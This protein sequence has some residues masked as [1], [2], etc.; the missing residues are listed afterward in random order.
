MSKDKNIFSTS[1]CLPLDTILRYVNEELSKKEMHTVEKH[2][3]DCELCQEAV[4]G[5]SLME[6]RQVVAGRISDLNQ[7]IVKEQKIFNY[8]RIAA[9]IAA[10]AILA[11]GLVYLSHQ[12][13]TKDSLIVNKN[14]KDATP[15]HAPNNQ[16]SNE[17]KSI[18]VEDNLQKKQD[19]FVNEEDIQSDALIR[20]QPETVIS[21][22]KAENSSEAENTESRIN[23][24]VIY[25]DTII[26]ESELNRNTRSVTTPENTVKDKQ[27]AIQESKNLERNQ[28]GDNNK[29]KKKSPST[30]A[31]VSN[32]EDK[33][34]ESITGP[35]LS[36]PAISEGIEKY[37]Q[38]KYK[39]ASAV[40]ELI[41]KSEPFNSDA[42]YY[43]GLSYYGLELWDLAIK[44][45]RRIDNKSNFFHEAR[46]NK[47]QAMIKKGDKEAAKI[48]LMDISKEEGPYKIRAAEE[49]K[50]L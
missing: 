3:L 37:N 16:T 12:M 43:N 10:V 19:G 14:S 39:E 21:Q 20:T 11:S 48:L 13:N 18:A 32:N 47:V 2:M 8:Q 49:L 36:V 41:L 27:E 25:A 50:K 22:R 46:W 44:N 23:S 35:D 24:P 29:A 17:N 6:N 30:Y 15:I 7:R 4:E 38:K 45:L 31:A 26:Q 28:K 42:L 1:G 5:Y 9:S 34:K 33:K 40:F